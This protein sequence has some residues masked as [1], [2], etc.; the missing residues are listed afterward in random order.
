MRKTAYAVSWLAFAAGVML[1]VG[2]ATGSVVRERDEGFGDPYVEAVARYQGDPMP[3]PEFRLGM[4][5][6]VVG[7]GAAILAV[8]GMVFSLR[9]RSA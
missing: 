1:I 8:P 9:R 2:G 6:A 3:S 5:H 4:A 7:C